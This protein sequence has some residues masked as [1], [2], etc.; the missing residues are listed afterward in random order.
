MAIFSEA[1]INQVWEK[2][3]VVIGYSQDTF[4]KDTC[5]AWI[6]K[7]KYAS[8]ANLGWQVNYVYPASKGG[9]DDLENLRPMHWKNNLSKADNYPSYQCAI[10]SSDNKN[11]KSDESRTINEALQETLKTKL[12]SNKY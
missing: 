7:D 1:K 11:V 8:E 10:K 9:N 5:G 6:Q 3:L 12:K 2:G 4:R